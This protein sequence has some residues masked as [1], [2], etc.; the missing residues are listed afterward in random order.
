MSGKGK[1]KVRI[2]ARED[3]VADLAAYIAAGFECS[4]PAVK[5]DGGTVRAYITVDLDAPKQ[6]A[7]GGG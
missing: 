4:Q 6:Q 2:T 7:V 3:V 1:V 5:R